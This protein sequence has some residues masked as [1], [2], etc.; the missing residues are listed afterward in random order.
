MLTSI[1]RV[2]YYFA[3][4]LPGMIWR[5]VFDNKFLGRWW[6]SRYH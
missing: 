2:C 1:A 4:D 5:A 3:I 6:R